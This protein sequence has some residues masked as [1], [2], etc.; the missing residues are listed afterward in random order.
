M[1]NMTSNDFCKTLNEIVN[2]Y[3]LNKHAPSF[4]A[5]NGLT[6]LKSVIAFL[7]LMGMEVVSFGEE[8]WPKEYFALKHAGQELIDEI[9]RIQEMKKV[10]ISKKEYE[11]AARLRDDER[12]AFDLLAPYVAQDLFDH[13][14][15]FYLTQPNRIVWAISEENPIFIE[16]QNVVSNIPEL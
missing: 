10:A 16:F 4:R 3:K 13:D 5:Y 14:G 12:K 6:H 11:H 7:R 2:R 9:A 15:P 8:D 1:A